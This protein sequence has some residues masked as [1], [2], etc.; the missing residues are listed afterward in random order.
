LAI[1]QLLATRSP[2][3]HILLGCRDIQKGNDAVADLRTRR[4][5]TSQVDVLGIDI[6][7]DERIRAALQ[8]VREKYKKLDGQ[9]H[10]PEPYSKKTQKKVRS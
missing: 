1:V 3:D 2:Q 10:P 9:C 8:E 7:S 4:G 5:I 6:L